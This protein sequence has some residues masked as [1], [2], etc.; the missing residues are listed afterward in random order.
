MDDPKSNPLVPTVP[1]PATATP[2]LSSDKSAPLKLVDLK[3]PPKEPAK[4]PESETEKKGEDDRL[5]WF[6]RAKISGIA[7]AKSDAA[8][9][10][11]PP[12]K[13]T[14]DAELKLNKG[15]KNE[16]LKLDQLKKPGEK[17]LIPTPTTFKGD[18]NPSTSFIDTELAKLN[19]L[20][21]KKATS[22]FVEDTLAKLLVPDNPETKTPETGEILID[23]TKGDILGIPYI[24]LCTHQ[25]S[26]AKFIVND[27]DD[28][29]RKQLLKH[30]K[31]EIEAGF[32]NG[33]K[34]NM[35]VGV[36]FSIGRKFPDGTEVEVV[37]VSQKM[38]TGAQAIQVAG[39]VQQ[40]LADEKT[41][42][43]ITS[44]FEGEAVYM[45]GGKGMTA[46]HATLPLTSRVRITNTA[47][48]KTTIVTINDKSIGPGGWVLEL[49]KDAAKALGLEQT[50]AIKVKAEVL[51]TEA[52]KK[53]REAK[54]P[55]PKDVAIPATDKPAP[56]LPGKPTA[57]PVVPLDGGP[58][59]AEV[60]KSDRKPLAPSATAETEKQQQ[61]PVQEKFAVPTSNNA[62]ANFQ[63][64]M[65][66]ISDR[67]PREQNLN[68]QLFTKAV[69]LKINDLSLFKLTGAGNISVSQTML[70]AAQKDA[71]LKGQTIIAR[72]N[73]IT[74]SAAGGGSPSGVVLDYQANR[75]AFINVSV[76]R[77]MGVQLQ[78]GYGA[79]TVKGF[80]VNDKTVVSATAVS[81]QPPKQ[82]PT[83]I[84]QAPEWGTIKL[85]EPIIPGSPYTWAIATRNG[86]R[87]PTKD[88]M[89]KIIKIAQVITPLTAKTVG[90]GKSWG[91]TSWYRDPATNAATPGA[92]PNSE[93]MTGG[94]VDFYYD[95]NGGEMA[96][97][98]ELEGS[99]EGGLAVKHGGFV[100]I[101]V[102]PRGRWNY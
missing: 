71:T 97:F 7:G 32:V 74:Q 45:G 1:P 5:R 78:S 92:A 53:A 90:A 10:P 27:P 39:A 73:T 23:S 19:K 4:T 70:E 62:S 93:H 80:N 84:I 6:F 46:S 25:V 54:N 22:N 68:A 18:A 63:E 21:D 89:G 101:D 29:I 65:Q 72:G 30:S 42:E 57:T 87:V 61:K 85:A 16:P 82:H 12:A 67:S 13:D 99:Y 48:N 52:E 86:E 14:K 75:A 15:P 20:G 8:I 91:I 9:A 102:G 2:P 41:K 79:I 55:K 11:A 33:F 44:T 36:I 34:L 96:L 76:K 28:S 88:V 31:V 40:P 69:D 38:A 37:D 98:R 56:A 94:A 64:E 3:K 51:E 47:N 35:F 77:R 83:G 17:E 43:L 95:T 59:T 26:T 50:G 49:S 58:S 81:T 66:K 100:H 60:K 24:K